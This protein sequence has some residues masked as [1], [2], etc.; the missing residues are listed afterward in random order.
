MFADVESGTGKPVDELSQS[1]YGI[2]GALDIYQAQNHGCGAVDM[3]GAEDML[4]GMASGAQ[5]PSVATKAAAVAANVYNPSTAHDMPMI[6]ATVKDFTDPT[7]HRIP[8]GT[9]TFGDAIVDLPNVIGDWLG[10]LVDNFHLAGPVAA[11]MNVVTG[12][13]LQW[14]M[15]GFLGLRLFSMFRTTFAPQPYARGPVSLIYYKTPTAT[16]E[17]V[18]VYLKNSAQVEVRETRDDDQG[19][20]MIGVPI[21]HSGKA[22]RAFAHLKSRANLDYVRV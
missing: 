1:L 13:G 15:Y 16:A 2:K 6:G 8:P 20:T 5:Y 9:E 18:L 14:L 12:G 19:M 4:T 11:I 17:P 21:Y 3:T 7:I 10:D 22:D